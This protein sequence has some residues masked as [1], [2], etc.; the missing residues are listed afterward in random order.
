MGL[1]E[2]C[3]RRPVLATVMN[4]LILLLGGI[5][6][7]RLSL[8]EY[9]DIEQPTVT[10]NTRY[11]GAS[12]EIIETQ[13]T[14]ILENQLAAVDGVDL[15]K[16]SSRAEQSQ[17][18]LTMDIERD[19]DLAANE[20]RDRIGQ[21]RSLLPQEVLDPVVA[22]GNLSSGQI[23]W[24]SVLGDTM[25]SLELS[26]FA[27]TVVADR[28]ESLPGVA[29]V[30]M[31][32][33]RRYA[34]RIWIDRAR[35]AAY[36]L[37]TQDIEAALKAQ[38]VEV[39][40]GKLENVAREFTI[41]SDTSLTE[42]KQFRE[43]VL[44]NSDGY[45]VRLGDVADV[46]LGPE[47]D[48]VRAEFNAKIGIAV[49]ITKQSNANALDVARAVKAEMAAI[50]KILPPGLQIGMAY[51]KT[52]FIDR[53]IESVYATI[54][55]AAG[56]VVL[57]IFF[58]L[59]S[60]R[61][62]LIPML[63]IPISLIGGFFL[64]YVLNFSINTL[65]LLSVVVAIG[66]VVD[67]AIV[68]LENCFRQV[69]A[70][71][72]PMD[73]AIS[74][75]RQIAFAV[76]AMTVTLAAVFVPVAFATGLT[77][78]FFVEFALTLAGIVMVSGFIA[79]TLTPLMCSRLLRPSRNPNVF[80]RAVE[81]GLNGLKSV[82]LRML[83]GVLKARFVVVVLA[84]GFAAASVYLFLTLPSELAPPEDRGMV[85][86][87]L[88]MPE[89]STVEHTTT[90]AHEMQQMIL[91]LPEARFAFAMIGQPVPSMASAYAGVADWADRDRSVHDMI[92]E[93]RGKM[94]QIRGGLAFPNIPP[95][96]DQD[97]NARPVDF[98]VL[99]NSGTHQDLKGVVDKLMA[100]IRTNPKI[101]SPDTDLKLNQPQLRIDMNRDKL[102]ALDIDVDTVGRTLETM[103]GGRKVTRFKR[104]SEQY[105]VIVQ[106]ADVD[107]RNPDDL[108]SIFVRTKRGDMVQVANLVTLTE[109]V[110]PVELVHFNR[111]RSAKVTANLAPGYSLGEAL[112]FLEA[113]AAKINAGA[114]I[115]FDVD[116]VSREF[117]KAAGSMSLTFGLALAFIYLVLAAQFESFSDPIVIL[118]AVPLAICGA[119]A[120]IKLTGGSLNIYSQI[121]LVT[122]VGLISKHG[123]L[124][125]EFANRLRDKGL[126][127]DHAVLGA[128]ELRLRPILMTTGAMILGAMPLAF[129]S[130]AGHEGRQAIGWVIVGGMSFGTLLTV[131]VVPTFYVLVNR[132]KVRKP[133]PT[134]HTV[135]A[136]A[137]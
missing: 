109:D 137:E 132:M 83:R 53:S 119:L 24:I 11:P 33:N 110:A 100:A 63:T 50:E 105:D 106:V 54:A 88:I 126:P 131:F 37:T 87:M 51:D 134:T 90:Y 21:A 97:T 1:P 75:S 122:L 120:T 39:P 71:K 81:G 20:V 101:V 59:R 40:A 45:L 74:G 93:L 108:K 27:E 125:V 43:I 16:S 102:A 13:V 5:A 118:L 17:I 127:I 9:P 7:D 41:L 2:L 133:V 115:G 55:E 112:A 79:L 135:P 58:F 44:K 77:G 116:G 34:M 114:D 57:V 29:N 69:E 66:L 94:F 62:T 22:K 48:R 92:A 26:E 8:R 32:G 35:L 123:I 12:A 52:A 31:V 82:Y 98:V 111:M 72:P 67:D 78:R 25:S 46:E 47:D 89:G 10:V 38:N 49:G 68:V 107:R 124:I 15:M 23:M 4:V 130:G 103:M 80:D 136:P 96:M 6:I 61:A 117:K 73:A 64:M 60:A 56:L 14:E 95:P 85:I 128:A 19:L 129:A 18:V 91:E 28:F 113:E 76:V 70:G 65:T 99:T 104:G 36:E 42:P 84:G 86:G 121:G 3:I 30:R